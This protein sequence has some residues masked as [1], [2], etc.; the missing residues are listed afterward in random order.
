[1]HT[2]Q[3]ALAL[4]LGLTLF[5]TNCA[6][7]FGPRTIP[8]AR[9]DYNDRIAR[10]QNDQLLLNL[11]RLR[12]RDTPVFLDVGTV[13]AQYT[14][15][16]RVGVGPTLNVDGVAGTELGVDVGGS[17]KE[18]PT[19]TYEPV[20]GAEFTQRLLA[21]IAAQT[22][23]LFAQSGW[24][25]ERL[26]MC[27]VDSV[28]GVT[29]APAAAG[30]TPSKLPDN[31]RFQEVAALLRELQLSGELQFRSSR[32][33]AKDAVTET[34][35]VISATGAD[36]AS[37]E[38]AR[39]LRSLLGMEPGI[40]AFRLV[41]PSGIRRNDEVRL[42]GRSLLGTLFFLS[43]NV[44]PPSAHQTQGLVKDPDGAGSWTS[45]TGNLLRVASSESEPSDA[46]VRIR[47]RGHWYFITDNDLNSKATFNL[48]MYLLSLQSAGS[49]SVDAMLTVGVGQ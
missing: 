9:F 21:P 49:K 8:A 43:Q 30:P 35:L 31:R 4:I 45:L 16:A 33:V 10:S 40:E 27:C 2:R 39:E 42:A 34:F 44:E 19:I 26:L 36:G 15:D 41:P 18:N 48:L 37:S 32:E 13:I 5:T 29:N 12:Y 23:A 22:L 46:F 38:A 17:Y 7:R 24:S 25:V 11:V 3:G 6:T 47:Y 28:N 20:T 14:F 1:M